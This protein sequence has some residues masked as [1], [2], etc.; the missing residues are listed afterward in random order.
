MRLDRLLGAYKGVPAAHVAGPPPIADDT[1]IKTYPG[2]YAPASGLNPEVTP[3]SVRMKIYRL[4][5]RLI[6][7]HC[8]ARGI[9]FLP[10]PAGGLD[11]EGVFWHPRAARKTPHTAMP[12][13]GAMCWK[14]S[15][16]L[17]ARH[18]PMPGAALVRP[19]REAEAA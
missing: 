2:N 11:A 13:T 10:P 8:E 14:R 6:A 17:A 3:R 7:A 18:V 12:S 19:V 16:R 9:A 15:R 4:Q 5:N 1:H